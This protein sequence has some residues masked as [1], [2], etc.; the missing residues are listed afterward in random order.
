MFLW[1]SI[2]PWGTTGLAPP[3][4]RTIDGVAGADSIAPPPA[5]PRLWC[6]HCNTQLELRGN[7]MGIRGELHLVV[8]MGCL[9]GYGGLLGFLLDLMGVTGTFSHWKFYPMGFFFRGAWVKTMGGTMGKW[10][11]EGI[12][13]D[14]MVNLSIYVNP[15]L[16]WFS[17]AT[18]IGD[19]NGT[20]PNK[21]LGFI[22]PGLTL[23][24]GND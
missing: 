2:T 24:S 9:W 8:S 10:W 3:A 11:F 14:L 17:Q 7:P 15:E 18:V 21:S 4:W 6:H 1:F 20:P 22:N 16:W 19:C 12:E 23:P 13:W 5:N